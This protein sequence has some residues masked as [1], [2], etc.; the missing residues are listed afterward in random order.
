MDDAHICLGR[1][2]GAIFQ[3]LVNVPFWGYWTSPYSSHLVDH[4]PNGWVMWNMGTF[5]DPCFCW[6]LLG[7]LVIAI[8]LPIELEGW[9]ACQRQVTGSLR[10]WSWFVGVSFLGDSHWPHLV[11]SGLRQVINIFAWI[12]PIPAVSFP[13]IEYSPMETRFSLF[14]IWYVWNW[15]GYNYYS[16]VVWNMFFFPQ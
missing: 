14:S 4:I 5:N 8:S 3:G 13:N 2:Y 7:F 10:F 1:S 15:F 6:G 9:K 12:I 11:Q 16:L